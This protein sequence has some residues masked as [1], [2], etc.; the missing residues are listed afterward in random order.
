[1][2]PND[3]INLSDKEAVETALHTF[4]SVSVFC[5]CFCRLSFA[6]YLTFLFPVTNGASFYGAIIGRN[7][8]KDQK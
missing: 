6:L 4:S 7:L 1:M 3:I 8:G 5:V 2:Y